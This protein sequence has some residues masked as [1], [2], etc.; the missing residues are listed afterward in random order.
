MELSAT[1]SARGLRR[2]QDQA[3]SEPRAPGSSFIVF[4]AHC[5]WGH[6]RLL[7]QALAP[8]P[9][10]PEM[11][12]AR[13]GEAEAELG[14]LHS[15]GLITTSDPKELPGSMVAEWV[16]GLWSPHPPTCIHLAFQPADGAEH[17]SM[18]GTRG[19]AGRRQGGA[20]PSMEFPR[21]G[22]AIKQGD[23]ELKCSPTGGCFEGS[24]IDVSKEQWDDLP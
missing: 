18:L 21:R 12:G 16:A 11:A 14:H 3:G 13:A 22:T 20:L 5:L 1:P 15:L 6:S 24:S 19:T 4:G 8:A 23:Q 10:F 2:V 9:V 17:L 7:S